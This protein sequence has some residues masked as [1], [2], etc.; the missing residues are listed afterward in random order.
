MIGIIFRTAPA[1]TAGEQLDNQV[2]V[3]HFDGLAALPLMV[4]GV[5]RVE[6]ASTTLAEP[7]D[8][9]DVVTSAPQVSWDPMLDVVPSVIRLSS[10]RARKMHLGLWLSRKT[11][12]GTSGFIGS[13]GRRG[14]FGRTVDVEHSGL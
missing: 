5:E 6:N 3:K 11:Q 7:Q 12:P 1:D 8:V 9:V 4:V 2:L 13:D 10:L 14:A